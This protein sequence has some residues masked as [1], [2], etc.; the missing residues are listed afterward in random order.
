MSQTHNIQDSLKPIVALCKRRGF[1]YP[2]SEIYGGFA[3]TYSF[4]PYGAELKKNIKDLWWKMFV[5]SRKDMLGLDGPILLHPKAWLASGHLE[6]FNDALIDCKA[7]KNRF[8]CDHLIEEA[9]GENA[10]G[11]T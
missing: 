10:D 7:C 1:I 5:Q 9:L 6:G 2:G 8:R 4:G 3:N 11:L